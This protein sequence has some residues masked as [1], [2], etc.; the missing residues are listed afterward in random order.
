MKAEDLM[1][2][3]WVSYNGTAITVE[4]KHVDIPH[5]QEEVMITSVDVEP[6]KLTAEILEKNGFVLVQKENEEDN[7]YEEWKYENGLISIRF[8][9]TV[10][11]LEVHN[12]GENSPVKTANYYTDG[13]EIY[14]HELQHLFRMCSVEREIKL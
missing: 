4:N 1:I 10:K 14:V 12:G 3:D 5:G 8:E 13:D 2:G 6:I 11:W 9:P 7:K